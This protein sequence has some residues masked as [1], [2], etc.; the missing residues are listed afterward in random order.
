MNIS[1]RHHLQS[2]P[3]F[4]FKSTCLS[5]HFDHQCPFLTPSSF[6]ASVE[7]HRWFKLQGFPLPGCP[8][9]YVCCEVRQASLLFPFLA[10]P[11]QAPESSSVSDFILGP[12]YRWSR[13][14][15]SRG[16]SCLIFSLGILTAQCLAL[17]HV[18]YKI[19]IILSVLFVHCNTFIKRCFSPVERFI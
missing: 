17:S 5:S 12:N 4:F 13:T 15:P 18:C 1:P 2:Y 16:T 19:I 14:L 9:L 11:P 7:G 6:I 8:W 10:N 3:I